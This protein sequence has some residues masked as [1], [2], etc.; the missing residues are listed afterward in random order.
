MD[1]AVSSLPEDKGEFLMRNI[2]VIEIISMFA[3][4][5]YNALEVGL[6]T[7]DCFKYYRGLYFWSMQVA[8]WGILVHAIPGMIRYMALSPN[9]P[10]AIPFVLGWNAMVTGQPIVLYSR[11]HL[12]VN[13]LDQLRWVLWMIIGTFFTLN[14][15]MTILFLE[16][17]LGHGRFTQAAAIFDRIQL[18]GF[19][20]QDYIICGIYIREALRALRPVF[21]MRGRDGGKLIIQLIAINVI[22][23]LMNTVLIVTEFKVHFIEISLKTVV[24]SVKLKLEFSILTRLRRLTRASPCICQNQPGSP[25]R[26]SDINLFHMKTSQMR[27]APD[28]EAPPFSTEMTGPTRP[29]SIYN[30]TR[31]F[32]DALRE[33]ASTEN[34]SSVDHSPT[35]SILS[36]PSLSFPSDGSLNHDL[37][38]LT[39]TRST[40]E[41]CLVV[42]P[43]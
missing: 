11:L 23:V 40:V 18:V 6:M 34:M 24:Y 8:S 25:R 7:F 33:T 19:C 38:G 2:S 16:V 27:T 1:T 43:K 9:L 13:D 20:L 10:M 4:G 32:H 22:V 37:V 30:G 35:A 21:E 12:V 26:S 41:T 15:P 31:D 28:V 3:I 36:P 29:S 42:N 5:S 14:I 39:S 17:N